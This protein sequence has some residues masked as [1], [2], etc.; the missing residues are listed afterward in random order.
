MRPPTGGRMR[1]P[2]PDWGYTSVMPTSDNDEP[3][4]AAGGEDDGERYGP[5]LVR[6]MV[7]EDGRALI[8]FDRAEPGERE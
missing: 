4:A 2:V 5:L 7:K 6:R 3:V 1:P 8:R